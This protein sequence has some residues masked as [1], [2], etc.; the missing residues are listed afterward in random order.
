MVSVAE[1]YGARGGAAGSLT[2]GVIPAAGCAYVVCA[3]ELCA[4]CVR[5]VYELCGVCTRR[6]GVMFVLVCVVCVSVSVCLCVSVCCLVCVLCTT[7]YYITLLRADTLHP[8]TEY[9]IHRILVPNHTT[10]PPSP[11]RH[12]P[13]VRPAL[14]I[15]AIREPSWTPCLVFLY[16]L[17]P[18]YIHTIFNTLYSTVL[19]CV[20]S[21]LARPST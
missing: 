18:L 14:A 3:C 5:V 11:T 21:V 16:R 2:R 4:S 8:R 10:P 6:V 20:Y 12:P 7:Y 17:T 9:C 1:G 19:Y 13:P 15:T